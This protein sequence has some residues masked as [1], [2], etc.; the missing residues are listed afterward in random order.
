MKKKEKGILKNIDNSIPERKDLKLGKKVSDLA[1][2]PSENPNP[3]LRVDKERVLYDNKS[4]ENL[5]KI[6]EGDNI[7]VLLQ[8]IVHKVID[9]NIAMTTEIELNNFIYS[10]DITPIKEEGYANIYG[11]DITEHKITEEN[12]IKSEH[13]LKERVKELT[14]LYGI[15]ELAENPDISTDELLQGT[16]ALVP[17]AWQFPGIACARILFDNVEY[18]TENFKITEWKLS[19]STS[20]SEKVM[21]IEIYYFEDK[22]F[23]E[24]ERS[25]IYDIG[26]RLKLIIESK[27]KEED[28]LITLKNLKFSNQELQQFAYVASHDLQEPLRM[29]I[30]F[31]QLLE[32]R[33]KDKLD[34][35]ANDFIHFA[36]DGAIRMKGLI[37]DL[38]DY[39]R[40]IT[41]REP[42][43]KINFEKVLDDVILNLQMKIKETSAKISYDELPSLMADRTQLMQL[44]QNLISNALKFRSKKAPQIH[45]SAQHTH[46]EWIFSVKDNGIGMEQMFL[47][48]IFIIFQRLH[49]KDEYPGSGIGLAICKR[50][51]DRLN[52]RIWVESEVGKGS[53]FKFAIPIKN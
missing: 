37:N 30:S 28:L 32:K 20:V 23:L 35:D 15:S 25:L 49:T 29:V 39:S 21:E 43:K 31:T 14:C 52:G 3:I 7:P 5:F 2:F 10:L 33:Y 53:T 34:K 45:I 11:R 40:I 24:E 22:P 12:L 9:R 47:K 17:P 8:D 19:H 50:I 48:K 44:F 36:V 13:N 38:L 51:V 4:G 6:K 42:L 1:K 27:K 18:K 46:N 26:Y 16:L 41:R